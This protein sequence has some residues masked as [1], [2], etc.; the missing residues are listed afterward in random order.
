MTLSKF[1]IAGLAMSLAAPAMAQTY[2]GGLPAGTWIGGTEGNSDIATAE[3][4]REQLALVLLGNAHLSMFTLSESSEVRLEAQGRGAGDPVIDVL[5]MD[6]ASVGS[7]DDAGG[8]TSSATLLMLDP[9][10][11]C[12]Q[13]RS[14]DDAPLTATVRIGRPEF[15]ALTE[16]GAQMTGTGM[17]PPPATPDAAP[18]DTSEPVTDPVTPPPTATVA[19]GACGDAVPLGDG[20]IDGSLSAGLSATNSVNSVPTYVFELAAEAELT[21]RAENEEADP[22][23][24]LTGDDG[25]F[26]GENDDWDGL[27]SRLD[28]E[29]PLAPGTYC[30]GLRALNDGDLPVTVTVEAYDAQAALIELYELGDVAP[31]LDG[32]YPVTDLGTVSGRVT[33]SAAMQGEATTWFSFQV[34]QSGLV[35]IEAVSVDSGD[36]VIRIWDDLGREIAFNDDHQPNTYNSQVAVKIFPG[37]YLIGLKDISASSPD[38]RLVV[39]R[40]VAA[41]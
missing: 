32:S 4:Y 37:T 27:N 16:G 34:E 14:Y 26:H 13:T 19:S 36:P 40:Y 30:I 23:V 3:D 6:G 24:T 31:P 11:Y 20:P 35:V 1:I 25:T 12:M 21:I 33:G 39:E 38:L 41:Q 22:V 9:G 15:A 7:D 8:G 5:D 10:T 17:A 29:A 2:C 18:E 28:T